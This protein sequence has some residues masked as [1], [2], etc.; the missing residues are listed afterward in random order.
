M[1]QFKEKGKIIPV[2]LKIVSTGS[3]S[4]P[5]VYFFQSVFSFKVLHFVFFAFKSNCFPLVVYSE[6]QHG[7]PHCFLCHLIFCLLT[8]S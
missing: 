5:W 8:T 4:N 6:H 1:W 7:V 3:R 2:P